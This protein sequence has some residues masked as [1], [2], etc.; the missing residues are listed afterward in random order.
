[1]SLRW[2]LADPLALRA[3]VGTTFRGPAPSQSNADSRITALAFIAP[4]SAFKA[5][6]VLGNANLDPESATTLNFGVVWQPTDGMQL[7]VDYW[8]F[9]FSDPIVRENENQLVGA[10]T[11]YLTAVASN[12]DAVNPVASQIFCQGGNALR[13]RFG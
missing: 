7:T 6:D 9:D 4:T 5:V 10:Y 1:M 2:Q 8:S 3:S 13:R 12:P 11:A